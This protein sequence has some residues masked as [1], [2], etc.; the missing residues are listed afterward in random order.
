MF[1]CNYTATYGICDLSRFD[2]FFFND[3]ATTEIYT[4]S[5]HDALPILYETV[6]GHTL[7]VTSDMFN[8]ILDSLFL[9]RFV[10]DRK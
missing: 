10:L 5:L 7:Y 8:G 2:V 4:L 6:M 9:E 1:C 3:R